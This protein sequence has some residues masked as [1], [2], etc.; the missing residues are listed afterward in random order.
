MYCPLI[1]DE[2][3][4]PAYAV[5]YSFKSEPLASDEY[6]NR[7]FTFQVYFRPD[8]FPPALRRALS[9][10]KVKRGELATYFN[11]T[12]SRLPVQGAVI[13]E[14]NSSFCSGNYIDANWI[15][16]DPHCQDKVSFKNVTTPSDNITVQVEPVSPRPQEAVAAR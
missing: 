13:D 4:A 16:D 15:Q 1:Q 3:P 14:A 11:V 8:E 7:N 5:T 10:G 9:T 6:G 12:A 2:S